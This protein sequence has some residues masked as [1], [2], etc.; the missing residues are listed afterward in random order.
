MFKNRG[1]VFLF[2]T[3]MLLILVACGDKKEQTTQP[4]PTQSG[5]T[6]ETN[7]PANATTREI[8][9]LQGVATVPVKI[10]RIVV[11]SAA[12]I[13]HL[14]TIG[15]KPFGVNVEVRYGSDY[16]PYL[17][18][19]LEGVHLV[20]SADSPNLEAIAQLDPD[21][22]LVESRTAEKT[23]AELSKIAPTIVLGKEW[24]EY[25]D[26][27]TAWTQDLLT[28][29]ELY[30]KVDLA[31]A[32]IAELEL[33]TAEAKAKI[34]A[35]PDN[36]LA[37]I[38]V[39]DK[40]LQ[41]YAKKGHP[42]NSLLYNDLGFTPTALTP[43][44][45]RADLSLEVAPDLNADY[46]V[47]EVDSNGHDNLKMINESTLWNSVAAVKNKQ[48]FETDSFWLFKG[49]GVIGRGQIIDDKMIY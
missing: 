9:H 28:V 22:I 10:E 15:E 21:A 27:T 13:D 47:M 39:R 4:A 32:K 44:E 8:T 25:G 38:R 24:L 11:L 36:R 48:V 42:T 19:E 20:G 3:I 23:Y 31:K 6:Q 34:T 5:S 14:L 40:A 17:V 30:D 45:Q 7:E 12:Y 43:E 2:T 16:I 1:I 18:N 49:W 37:Y 29:A 26:D 41:I 46:I 33:K 35:L